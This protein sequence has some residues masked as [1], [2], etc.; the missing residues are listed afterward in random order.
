[1]SYV[2]LTT[3]VDW[4]HE[5]NRLPTSKELRLSDSGLRNTVPC[6]RQFNLTALEVLDISLNNFNTTIH[7]RNRRFA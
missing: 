7:Y 2:N 1:M 3:A 5:I 4:V 6:L